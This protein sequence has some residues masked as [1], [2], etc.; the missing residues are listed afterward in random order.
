[1]SEKFFSLWII[2]KPIMNTLLLKLYVEVAFNNS[3]KACVRNNFGLFICYRKAWFE[4]TSQSWT[5]ANENYLFLKRSRNIQCW[6]T[7]KS[8]LFQQT[9][10]KTSRIAI[11]KRPRPSKDFLFKTRRFGARPT[12]NWENVR[13]EL[14]FLNNYLKMW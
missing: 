10:G 3:F 13:C 4:G 6:S 14:A 11:S 1:M 12:T 8:T 2:V 9:V 5:T 7:K